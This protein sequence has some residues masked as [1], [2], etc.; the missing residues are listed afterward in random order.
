MH[1]SKSGQ[2][3][4][5]KHVGEHSQQRIEQPD[6]DLEDR[7]GAVAGL[8][9]QPQHKADEGQPDD[10]EADGLQPRC[11]GDGPERRNAASGKQEQ[12][13]NTGVGR[14]D[15]Q[16]PALA[17]AIDDPDQMADGEQP[18]AGDDRHPQQPGRRVKRFQ[19]KRRQQFGRTE[20]LPVERPE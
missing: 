7:R 9:A 11:V 16:H 17:I 10:P 15:E 6:Q 12:S 19:P 2:T 13:G 14:Q 1:Q 4:E 5:R 8:G 3:G 18:D 20:Q